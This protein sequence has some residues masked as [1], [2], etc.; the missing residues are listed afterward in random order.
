MASGMETDTHRHRDRGTYK[1]YFWKP[2]AGPP[3]A[4]A[5]LV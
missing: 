2:D 1:G 4:G 5:R 3:T